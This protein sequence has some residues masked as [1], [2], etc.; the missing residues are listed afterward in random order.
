MSAKQK[1]QKTH[2]RK[3]LSE[4]HRYQGKDR[5]TGKGSPRPRSRTPIRVLSSLRLPPQESATLRLSPPPNLSQL[6]LRAPYA[7]L[8]PSEYLVMHRTTPQRL[9]PL[10]QLTYPFPIHS[11][12]CL[13]QRFH[14]R[15]AI[16][17]LCRL[18]KE[19]LQ[20]AVPGQ[21]VRKGAEQ[22]ARSPG[23]LSTPPP[24]RLTPSLS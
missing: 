21:E 14:K 19:R 15:P 2:Q 23:T 16:A 7:I 3:S 24:T 4:N 12:R 22:R 5:E 10:S 20:V 8:P 18:G 17:P 9:L 6:S 11:S 13:G 1:Y